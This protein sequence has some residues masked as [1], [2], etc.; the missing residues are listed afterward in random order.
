M[1]V[2]V[3][4]LFIEYCHLVML[5]VYPDKVSKVLLIPE[6]TVAEPAIDPPT[7]AGATVMVASEELAG[8]QIPFVTTAL[9]FVVITRFVAV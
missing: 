6:H 1:S 8:V 7:E 9:Y 2:D 5:P 3:A 4:Q